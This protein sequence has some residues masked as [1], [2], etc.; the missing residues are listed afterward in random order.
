MPEIVFEPSAAG[1]GSS[2]TVEGRTRLV[3]VCDD[4]GAPVEFSCRSASCATCRIEVLEGADLLEP[5]RE[6]ELDVLDVFGGAER[7][8]LACQAV[9]RPG[10]G[11]LR[12]RAARD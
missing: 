12:V 9:V 2:A 10:P 1:P 11:L 3:D 5:P 8:R 7:H 6:D 4:T